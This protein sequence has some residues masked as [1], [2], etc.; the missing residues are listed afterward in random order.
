MASSII[1]K[2]R[3]LVAA[4]VIGFL[5]VTVA[6]TIIGAVSSFR[7]FLQ[8]PVADVVVVVVALA[9]IAA[10]VLWARQP[11]H[12]DRVAFVATITALGV[13]VFLANVFAPSLS[14]WGGTYFQAPLFILA[15]ITAVQAM[16]LLALELRG[17]LWLAKRS[18]KLALLVYALIL[19]ILLPASTILGDLLGA[20]SGLITFGEGYMVWHDV[21]VGEAFFWSPLLL[22]T[23]FR[24]LLG[25]SQVRRPLEPPTTAHGE[26]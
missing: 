11:G 9:T 26:Q 3:I 18:P 1:Q 17:Y 5:A 20:R 7:H 6:E 2:E 23:A 15:L 24:R 13:L 19:L 21:L 10:L 12:R 8:S 16:G 14:W 4:V 25:V 22:Y